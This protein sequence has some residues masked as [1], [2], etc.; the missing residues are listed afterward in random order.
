[1]PSYSGANHAVVHAQNERSCLGPL[2]TC[3]SCPE[4]AVLHAKTTGG[5]LVP[6]RLVI[7]VLKALFCMHK[8]TGDGWNQYSLFVCCVKHAVMCAQNH[9]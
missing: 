6:Q 7:L 3:Y 5:V 8:T 4:F 2:E 9:R 1:M